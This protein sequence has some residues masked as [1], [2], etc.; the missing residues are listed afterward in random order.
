MKKLPLLRELKGLKGK[1]I[2][3]R[4]DLNVPIKDGLVSDDF[5]IKKIIPTISNKELIKM[6]R[7]KYF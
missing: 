4:L 3:L 6:I 7:V 1:R 2:I 5:R